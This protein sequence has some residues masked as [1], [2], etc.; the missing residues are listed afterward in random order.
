MS[1]LTLLKLSH[2]TLEEKMP[3]TCLEQLQ[4]LKLHFLHVSV[5]CMGSIIQQASRLTFLDLDG[6]F[7][8]SDDNVKLPVAEMLR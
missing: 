6:C 1:A 4:T 2:A 8:T 3:A 5:A 7:F